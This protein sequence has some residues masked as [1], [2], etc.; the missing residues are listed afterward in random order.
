MKTV[1]F[2]AQLWGF[3]LVIIS[4]SLLI[5]PKRA[6]NILYVIEDEGALLLHGIMRVILGVAMVLT[7]NVW[8]ISWKLIITI[9]GWLL[10][11]SGT[12][13]LFIPSWIAKIIA[14]IKNGDLIPIGLTF[15]VLLGCALIYFSFTN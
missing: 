4:L 12:G 10:L 14:K 6:K 7:Y 11:L 2:L 15:L 13:I 8:D 1:N 9:L 3:S 5:N